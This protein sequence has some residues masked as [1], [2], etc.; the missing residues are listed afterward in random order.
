MAQLA[1][2]SDSWD[3]LTPWQLAPAPKHHLETLLHSN[4]GQDTACNL[5][6]G[7]SATSTLLLCL[8]VP[9]TE[10]PLTPFF[11][12]SFVPSLLLCAAQVAFFGGYPSAGSW[13]GVLH[14]AIL[15]LV[16][17]LCLCLYAL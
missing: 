15:P 12:F 1:W 4:K 3:T 11:F 7:S 2:V 13:P 14:S 16:L 5:S 6:D 17:G 8:S 10:L 9:P